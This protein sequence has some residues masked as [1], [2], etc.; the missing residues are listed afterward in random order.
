MQLL[1]LFAIVSTAF[2]FGPL[3]TA[4]ITN[5]GDLKMVSVIDKPLQYPKFYIRTTS[6]N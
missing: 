4:T 2:S 6:G 1:V 3:K 5:V